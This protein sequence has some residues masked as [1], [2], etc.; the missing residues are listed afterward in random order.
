VPERRDGPSSDALVALAKL[1]EKVADKGA[2]RRL[3]N[4]SNAMLDE[5]IAEAGLDPDSNAARTFRDLFGDLT[6]EE[7]RLLARMQTKI[8]ELSEEH[9]DL[10]EELGNPTV[11]KF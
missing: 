9:P 2:R 4:D 3:S 6:F 5:A 11:S 1:A 8:V 7:L 10:A